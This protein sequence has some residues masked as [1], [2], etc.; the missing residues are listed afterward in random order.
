M[1]GTGKI[2]VQTFYI[3]F[4]DDILRRKFV[5]FAREH[6]GSQKARISDFYSGPIFFLCCLQLLP[7]EI[8]MQHFI[9]QIYAGREERMIVSGMGDQFPQRVNEAAGQACYRPRKIAAAM[10]GPF[11][12]Y[13][14][15]MVHGGKEN[16]LGT[17]LL[18]LFPKLLK[19]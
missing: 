12:L 10:V 14:T 11:F 1:P 6:Y 4:L 8:Q 2:I 18:I 19:V 7:V 9:I 16:K 15:A 5:R 13:L 17:L 3:E